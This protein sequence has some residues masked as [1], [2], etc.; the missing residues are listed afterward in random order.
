MYGEA[1]YEEWGSV[2]LRD[3][4]TGQAIPEVFLRNWAP[5]WEGDYRVWAERAY[6][7]ADSMLKVR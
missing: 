1:L 2:S 4:F 5:T 6:E 3:W 7:I